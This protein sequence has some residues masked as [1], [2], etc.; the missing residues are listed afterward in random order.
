MDVPQPYKTA[1]VANLVGA[2][3]T[4]LVALPL[5]WLCIPVLAIAAA[6]FQAYIGYLM[7]QDEANPHAQNAAIAGI[8]GG[9]LTCNIVSLP[10]SVY[11]LLQIREAEV[12]GWLEQHGTPL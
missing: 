9:V 5:F 10:A 11:A 1:A 6:G 2:A 12:L 8:V 3:A 4:L 7:Y